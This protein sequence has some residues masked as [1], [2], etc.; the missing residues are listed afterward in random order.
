MRFT[1]E[2]V[3]EINDTMAAHMAIDGIDAIVKEATKN[4]DNK[5]KPIE[6][7]KEFYKLV[8]FKVAH[9]YDIEIA[10]M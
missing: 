10:C 8:L 2:A 7:P 9:Y 1:Y 3:L 6:I 5:G 4:I